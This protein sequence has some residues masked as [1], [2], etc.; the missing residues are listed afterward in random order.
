MSCKVVAAQGGG[1]DVVDRGVVVDHKDTLDE[2][3]A[4]AAIR[5]D[6]MGDVQRTEPDEGPEQADDGAA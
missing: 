5:N 3:R 2:A 1:Y 4:S 6:T